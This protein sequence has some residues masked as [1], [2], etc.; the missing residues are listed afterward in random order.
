MNHHPQRLARMTAFNI[1]QT[2]LAMS[3]RRNRIEN[4]LMFAVGFVAGMVAMLAF[5]VMP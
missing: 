2:T 3:R 1:A 4:A 5:L